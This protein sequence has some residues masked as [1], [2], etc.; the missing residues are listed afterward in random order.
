MLE[1]EWGSAKAAS[2]L[3]KHGVPFAYATRVLVDLHRLDTVDTRR[4][5][6]EERRITMGV[7]EGRVYVIAYT[8]RRSVIRLISAR[9]ANAR[10]TTQYH[11]LSAGPSH[12]P[13]L[14]PAQ[15]KRLKAIP[16]DYSDIPELPDDFWTRHPPAEREPK[17][18]VT[19]RLDARVLEFFRAQ[20]PR[21]QTR[22]NAV[23]RTYV[24]AHSQRG[25]SH[26]SRKTP[27]KAQV[28]RRRS[29]TPQRPRGRAR[30][31]GGVPAPKRRRDRAS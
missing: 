21:Y 28:D 13:A 9:K 20:G 14:T 10:E 24:A 26:K 22:I 27:G 23:L 25:V 16:I 15:A 29:T 18:Q 6:G 17:Q 11:T 31:Q 1:F 12:P 8:R 4:H 2:N 7:I 19:L 30:P 5:Y 3:T